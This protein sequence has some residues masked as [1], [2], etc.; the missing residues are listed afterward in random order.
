[1]F[2]KYFYKY[3]WHRG[4]DLFTH[5]Y[6]WRSSKLEKSIISLWCLMK[7]R[8][9]NI[10]NDITLL[11]PLFTGVTHKSTIISSL[12]A[13][14]EVSRDCLWRVKREHKSTHQNTKIGRHR[15][16]ESRKNLLWEKTWLK[17]M[18][19]LFVYRRRKELALR[20]EMRLQKM[21]P[22]FMYRRRILMVN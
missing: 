7:W 5:I 15:R 9:L 1:M 22:L 12:N 3:V 10:S 6:L 20:K 21:R 2:S 11:Y 14:P 18:S 16:V 19:L 4:F 17:K 8:P 13:W